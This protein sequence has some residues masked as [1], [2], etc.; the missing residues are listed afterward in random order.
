[1][2]DTIKLF[3]FVNTDFLTDSGSRTAQATHVV[4]RMVDK[5]VKASYES[6]ATP[7]ACI[8]YE[9]WNN[10]P[11]TL[12]YRCTNEQMEKLLKVKPEETIY[13]RDDL[14]GKDGKLLHMNVLTAICTY[15]GANIDTSG[16]QLL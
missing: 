13:F 11:T 14:K 9:K 6:F 3:V 7:E 2:S 8:R 4:H 5:L 16:Y 15:P 12:I 1:M 10:C